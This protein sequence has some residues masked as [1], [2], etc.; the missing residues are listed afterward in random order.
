M[1]LI[2]VRCN[3][4][5]DSSVARG[6][7]D[8]CADFFRGRREVAHRKANPAPGVH[9]VGQFIDPKECP[10]TV[11]DPVGEDRTV[12][13]LCGCDRLE[14][15]YGFAGGYGLG[16]YTFCL[17]CNTVLDFSEDTGE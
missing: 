8:D 3:Q 6:Y 12:C 11:V 15:G 2:C 14:P 16:A 9:A 10:Q 13:G 5:F 4:P 1:E 17:G 7:C